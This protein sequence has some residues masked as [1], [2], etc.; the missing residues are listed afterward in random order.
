LSADL[1][2]T[3]LLFSEF[4]FS[5]LDEPSFFEVSDLPPAPDDELDP[6]PLEEPPFD[7]FLA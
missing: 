4:D 6:L 1:S 2:E 3:E 5:E 7:D